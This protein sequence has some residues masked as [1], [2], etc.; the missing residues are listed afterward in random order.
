MRRDRKLST[1]LKLMLIGSLGVVF[2]MMAALVAFTLSESWQISAEAE[3]SL[4]ATIGW[5]SGST[6]PAT[7]VTSYFFTDDDYNILAEDPMGP[8]DLDLRIAQWCKAHDQTGVVS[9]VDLGDAICYAEMALGEWYEEPKANMLVAY[10]DVTSQ[11]DLVQRVSRVFCAIALL[12]GAAAGLAGWAVGKRIEAAELAQKH[13]Y[14]N[15]SH[16]LKTP[17]AAIRGYAEGVQDGVVDPARASGAIVRETERM[18]ALVEQILSLS[19]LEA[20]A[21]VLRLETLEVEDLVQDCLMPFEGIVRTRGLEVALELASGTI[22]ADADL[23][24]H[25]LENVLSNAM[26]HAQREVCIAYD[27]RRLAVENDGDLPSKQDVAHLFDRFHVGEGGSTGIGLALA[28]EI[29]ARHGWSLEA[30]LL[31]NRFRMVFDFGAA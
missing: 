15:M 24:G 27:G 20:G 9:K 8:T 31:D 10:V 14:E 26:R 23:M 19:R 11:S 2:A 7:R 12:G 28:H 4:D 25:A 16:E 17:L 21:V 1:R 18:S 6:A 5:E 29:V 22:E 3:A 30:E 13:F